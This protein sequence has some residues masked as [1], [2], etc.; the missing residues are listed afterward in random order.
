MLIDEDDF[1]EEEVAEVI[2]AEG[3]EEAIIG[4]A[5]Q[6]SHFFVV[7]DYRKVMEMLQRDMTPEEA[8]EFFEE[9]MVGSWLG[10]ATPAY[11]VN[12]AREPME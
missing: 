5:R 11:L 10:K 3:Y 2:F 12:R 4:V 7:Y 1:D 8:V 6:H 9:K